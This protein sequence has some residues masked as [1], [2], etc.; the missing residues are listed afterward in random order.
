MYIKN[1]HLCTEIM[2]D[3]DSSGSTVYLC[4]ELRFSYGDETLN[5]PIYPQV[6]KL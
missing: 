4:K 3:R 1:A 5:I 2:S 6:S